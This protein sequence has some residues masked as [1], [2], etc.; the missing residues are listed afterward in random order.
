VFT[1]GLVSIVSPWARPTSSRSTRHETWLVSTNADSFGRQLRSPVL[2]WP[3]EQDLE[4][5]D[6]TFPALDGVHVLKET[7]A[8]T[9][10]PMTA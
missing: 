6:V 2:H 9:D 3:S 10:S 1:V 5:E 7:P 4:Y 8:M